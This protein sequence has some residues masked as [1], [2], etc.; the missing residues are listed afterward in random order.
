MVS[1]QVGADDR[2]V[3]RGELAAVDLAKA[4]ADP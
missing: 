2:L 4:P 1:A 3:G